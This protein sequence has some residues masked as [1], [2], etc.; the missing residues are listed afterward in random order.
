MQW[1]QQLQAK[2]PTH[3]YA[4]N[5]KLLG[6]YSNLPWSN[7][8]DWSVDPTLTAKKT[9]PQACQALACRLADHLQLSVD[10]QLLDLGCGQG[11]SLKLWQQHYAVQVIEGV[12]LQPLHVE[13]MC[14]H[15][16][17]VTAIHCVDFLNLKQ[18]EF[19]KFDVVICIDAAYH[20]NLNAWLESVGPIL[21][22]KG[23]LGFHSL[24]WSDQFLNSNF[25]LQQKYRLLLKAADIDYADILTQSMLQQQLEVHAFEK[26]EVVDLSEAVLAGF[27]QYVAE[28]LKHTGQQRFDWLKIEMT[29]KLCRT[30]YQEGYIRYVQVTA[31]KK[32][33]S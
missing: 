9:Y 25:F 2:L 16:P 30:L 6:D 29:A 10:D 27:A 18:F 20:V 3:K 7:L 23:R 4:I 21:N 15:L 24:I 14:Q 28:D 1:F 12:E 5:A 26:I 31:H 33:E 11:A 8:G 22:S 19:R 13:H 32:G 17:H